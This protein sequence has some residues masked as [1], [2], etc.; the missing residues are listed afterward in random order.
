MLQECK[1]KLDIVIERA[2][3]IY[4]NKKIIAD[5][6]KD[7]D[8]SPGTIFLPVCSLLRD[9]ANQVTKIILNLETQ[10]TSIQTSISV[11]LL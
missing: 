10:R 11:V 5:N 8:P 2:Q 7:P 9:N 1:E 6:C 4:N 3:R